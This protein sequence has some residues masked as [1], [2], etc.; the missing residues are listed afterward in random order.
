MILKYRFNVLGMILKE[1]EC[2]HTFEDISLLQLLREHCLLGAFENFDY[3]LKARI[4]DKKDKNLLKI[5]EARDKDGRTLLHHAAEGGSKEIFKSLRKECPQL[6]VADTAANGY[7][8]LHL[9]CKSRKY[10]MCAFLLSDNNYKD[11]LGKQSS[12]GWNAAHFA[13]VGG[14]VKIMNL[15]KDKKLDITSSTKNGLSILDIACIHNHT[16]MCND[17]IKRIKQKQ[18]YLSLEKYDARGWTI[19]HFVAMVGNKDIFDKLTDSRVMKLKTNSKKTVLHIC[20][21]YGHSKLCKEIIM[22]HADMLHDE[23]ENGWNA[24][25]YAA[26]GGNLDVFKEIDKA[27]DCDISLDNLCKETDDGKTALHICCIYK[28]VKLCGYI[29]E[30][31]KS[32][33]NLINKKTKKLWTAAH[34]VAVEIKQD[35]SEEKLICILVENGMDIKSVTVDNYTVLTVACEHR[36]YRLIDFLIMNYPSLLDIETSKLEKVAEETKDKNID[37][38]IRDSILKHKQ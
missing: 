16:D 32:D 17:L 25:H 26:K 35:G 34:Y 37:S 33:R 13:A 8:V 6:S 36:N 2:E 3:L 22:K 12:Q 9:A 19:S 18:L 27:L 29:C 23:D 4:L 15:L 28:H 30:K 38:K 31:L 10:D 24:L 21:E 5:L 11:L 7:T 1:L 20:C 14:S